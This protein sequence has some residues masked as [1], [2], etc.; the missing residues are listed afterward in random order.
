MPFFLLDICRQVM[1]IFIRFCI[2]ARQYI[3]TLHGANGLL[4][5]LAA[6]VSKSKRTGIAT[7]EHLGPNKEKITS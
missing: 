5:N 7:L 3:Y 2:I 6:R 4:K 1:E